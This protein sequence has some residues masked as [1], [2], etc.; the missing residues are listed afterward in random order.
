MNSRQLQYALRL[1]QVGSFSQVAEELNITQPALSKQILALEKELGVKLFDRSATPLTLTPAGE[2]FIR[3]A[4]EL[5]YKEDQLVRSMTE[6]QV[7]QAGTLTIGITPFRSSYMIAEVME[8]VRRKFPKTQIRLREIGSSILRKEVAEGKYDFAIV[9]LPVNDALLDVHPLE[10]DKLVLAVPE[11]L[12]HLLKEQDSAVS[13]KDCKDLPFVVVGVTQEMR[14]LFDSLC[15]SED[16]SPEIAAEVVGLTTA[17]DVSQAGVGATIL[18]GQ[19]VAQRAASSLMHI[20][21]LKDAVYTRQ[22]AV[23]TRRGQYLSPAAQYA[24]SLLTE[25]K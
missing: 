16:I 9:N 15:V 20:F 10:P 8:K 3:R 18:P 25:C 13:F 22:P 17:W 23:V 11:S 6:F 5:L 2:A 19:F 7:G 1:S 21:D 14:R 12:V 4:E 24:I